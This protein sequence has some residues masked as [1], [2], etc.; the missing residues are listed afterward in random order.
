[1]AGIRLDVSA[2]E[3]FLPKNELDAMAPAVNEAAAS[4]EQGTCKGSEYLGWMD[5]PKN[6]SEADFAAI[7]A[8]AGRACSDAQVYVVVGIGGSYLG[9]RAV[10]DALR[11]METDSRTGYPE[12]IFAGTGLCSSTLNRVLSKCIGRSFRI[13]VIS[14]SGTTLEPA[15]AFRTLRTIMLERYGASEAARR[16]TAVTDGE[17][18][19]L[20]QLADGEGYETFVIPDDV[21]GRFSILTPVGL[22]PLAAAG[23]DVRAIMTGA[24][25]MRQACL[26]TDLR[27]NPAHLYAATRFGLYQKGFTTEVMSTFHG[28]LQTV[29]EWW[30]QLFGE[31]EGKGGEGIFPAST[32]FTTD[33]HSM[34]QYIQDGRR[35]LQETFLCVRNAVS[36]LT[37]PGD[38]QIS[39]DKPANLDGLNYLAG[40]TLDDINWKAYEGTKAAHGAGGVPCSSIEIDAITPEVV[41]ALLYM[42][43]K[44]VAVSGLMLG[45]NPFDQPGVETYKKEMFRLLGKPQ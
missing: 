36:R 44:A 19:A 21:G 4:L 32:V 35:N 16:I 30:K 40:R 10:L 8:S 29:Q 39:D 3:E 34:G 33:L 13:C 45:V 37:V 24:E 43:E 12:I 41:G 42:F 38:T 7:E 18:G 2:T 14:K 31:S 23:I 11:G 28:D 22:V 1:M 15:V 27:S 26:S 9:A 6:I 17:R 5:L 20:R 25:K